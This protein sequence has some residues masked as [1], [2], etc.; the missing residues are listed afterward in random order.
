MQNREITTYT[1]KLSSVQA[2]RLEQ[3]LQ[4]KGYAFKQLDHAEFVAIGEKIRIVYYTSGKLMVQ[5]K[6]TNNFVTFFLEPEI[7]G[8]AKLGYEDVLDPERLRPRI[9]IDESGKGDFFG[10]LCIAGVYVNE[11]IVKDFE[12]AGIRDSKSIASDTQIAQLAKHITRHRS[13]VFTIVRIGNESYNR[14]YSKMQSLNTMLA[15]GHARAIENLMRQRNRMIP[16]AQIAISDQFASS[17]KVIES[18]LMTLGK[19]IKLTQR[20]KAESDLAVAAASILARHEFI[21]GLRKLEKKY[22]LALPK[23]AGN[24]VDRA[25][26]AFVQQHGKETLGQVSK[27]HFRNAYRAIGLPEPPRK[28]FTHKSPKKHPR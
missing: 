2:K 13:S 22:E 11:S 20:H 8:E 5:G 19:E 26:S 9:G 16:K 4:E 23:G 1:C 17:K 12:S 7:L 21:M 14:L 27:L 3:C 24:K 6:N 10:P 28:I 25:A 15:W 18:A